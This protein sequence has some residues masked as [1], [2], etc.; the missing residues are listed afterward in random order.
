MNE[1]AKEKPSFLL[2]RFDYISPTE[3][4]MLLYSPMAAVDL[5]DYHKKL[6]GRLFMCDTFQ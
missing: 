6:A 2:L 3:T 4:A 1:S 5:A